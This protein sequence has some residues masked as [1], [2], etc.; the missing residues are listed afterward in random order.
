MERAHDDL[1]VQAVRRERRGPLAERHPD[2]V[3]LRRRHRRNPRG[4]AP[5]RTRSRSPSS[6]AHAASS[7]ARQSSAASAAAWATRA[8]GERRADLPQRLRH[9]RRRQRVA[10]PQPG[11]PVRLREGAQHDE[12]AGA[13]RAG[14]LP[15]T[16]SGSVTNSRYASSS[17][18]STSG[19][20]AA[21]KRS[22]SSR[23]TAVPVGLFGLQTNTSRVRGVTAAAI[24]SRS[25]RNSRV[26]R[27]RPLRRPLDLG[28]DRVRLERPPR[29]D[30]LVRRLRGT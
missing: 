18:T 9:L 26:Q 22:N 25:W 30:D 29:V 19:P 14:S 8:H 7:S 23:R 3:G 27:H 21:R 10:H 13:R 4:A 28:H 16:A 6:S 5:P 1:L 24:A 17:A 15:S 11:E 12:V 20:T 2:E